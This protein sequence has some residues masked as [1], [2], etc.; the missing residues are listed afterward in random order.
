MRFFRPARSSSRSASSRAAFCASPVASLAFL[1]ADRSALRWARLTAVRALV[2]RIA[3]LAERVRGTVYLG[4]RV[5][6]KFRV[7]GQAGPGKP[8]KLRPKAPKCKRAI[9]FAQWASL[10]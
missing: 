3:F 6:N 10:L 9:A 1:T 2:W 5:E 7:S 4:C 8:E